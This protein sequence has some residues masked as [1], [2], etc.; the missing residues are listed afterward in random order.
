V[1]PR[2][3]RSGGCPSTNSVFFSLTTM[4]FV[5]F[6]GNQLGNFSKL[7]FPGPVAKV[8]M[9][10]GEIAQGLRMPTALLKVMSSN[11]SNNMMAH[12]HL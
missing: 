12:N 9:W 1:A 4:G 6:L 2:E 7:M 11:P 10:A 5:S 3:R 8:E